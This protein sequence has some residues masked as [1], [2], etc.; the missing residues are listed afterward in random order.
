MARWADLAR[1]VA[2]GD[3]SAEAE[4]ADLFLRRAWV[5]ASV[6][7]HD[8][9]AARDVA[10]DVMLA[11]LESLRAGRLRDPRNL[12]AFV[13]G[14]ARNLVNNHH[15]HEA[16]LRESLEDPP[17]PPAAT[18][19]LQAGIDRE[20]RGLVRKALGHLTGLDRRIFLLTLV[21]GMKPREIA[22]ILGLKTGLVR[23]HKARAVRIVTD[24][25]ERATRRHAPDHTRVNVL[26]S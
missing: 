2:S 11:V 22:P 7:L 10:Q 23:T 26:K 21:Q 4:V 19:P 3:A 15:R 25:I 6:R 24:E 13:L 9:E 1:R 17:G 18:D 16:R 14:T 8:A 12:S 20:R 5:F